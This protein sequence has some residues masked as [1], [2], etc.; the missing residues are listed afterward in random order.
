MLVNIVITADNMHACLYVHK[1]LVT[2]A[3]MKSRLL[4]RWE[5]HSMQKLRRYD[6][7]RRIENVSCD[8]D[9]TH[10]WSVLSSE[11]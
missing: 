3:S 2:P 10:F 4:W 11:S 6:C 9:H 8:P 7:R 1:T 5:N